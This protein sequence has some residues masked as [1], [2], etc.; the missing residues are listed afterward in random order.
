MGYLSIHKELEALTLEEMNEVEEFIIFLKI[1]SKPDSYKNL[2]YNLDMLDE[3]EIKIL[4]Q[5]IEEDLFTEL[6]EYMDKNN[7]IIPD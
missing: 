2:I 5:V 4:T 7:Y 1:R 3:K 6:K